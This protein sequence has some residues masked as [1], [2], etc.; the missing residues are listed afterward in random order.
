MKFRWYNNDPLKMF[1]L[2]ALEKNIKHNRLAIWDSVRYRR[3][4]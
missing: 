1:L 4:F 2:F 3:L